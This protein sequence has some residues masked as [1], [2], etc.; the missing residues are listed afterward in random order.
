VRGQ[1]GLRGHPFN[2][3]NDSAWL[4][5]PGSRRRSPEPAA[6]SRAAPRASLRRQWRDVRP[7]RSAPC[8]QQWWQHGL[9]RRLVRRRSAMRT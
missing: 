6:W 3:I 1:D 5:V 4:R 2:R 9:V 7:C 8:S